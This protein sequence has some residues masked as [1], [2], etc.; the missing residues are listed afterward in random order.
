MLGLYFGNYLMRK[1]VISQSQ[2]DE[3]MLQQQK[4]CAKLGLIAVA[5][6]LLTVKQADEIN[7]IQRRM[8]KR[9]GDI[10]I[11]KGYLLPEEVTYLL[12]LQ[13]NSYLKFVQTCSD[14]N[15][16]SVKELED[17]LEAY[18]I[19]HEF[20]KM[21][22]LAFK[23]G[24]L[25]R[26]LST[27]VTIDN[28]FAYELIS[29]AV[30]NMIRLVNNKLILN[31][32]TKTQEYSFGSLAFQ[33]MVG[34]Q[35]IF[36]GLACKDR[37]LLA[38]ANSFAK[39]EF[40]EMDDDSFDSVCEFINCTNGLYASKLSFDD[41]SIDMTPPLSYS[42]QTAKAKD[43]F[44]IVPMLIEDKQVDLLVTVSNQVEII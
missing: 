41:I 14:H 44:Y 40:A 31:K 28:P 4:S 29:L 5:E 17:Q 35:D 26:I 42:N 15:I 22:I 24:D 3:I 21:D 9:F 1:G 16:L 38:V 33:Q 19:D 37:E 34:D 12:N 30:R 27:Y 39:E 20:T 6:K 2:F 25:D 10:A 36:V 23:S 43:N 11:E 8:D 32:V 7:E 13:G 18:R